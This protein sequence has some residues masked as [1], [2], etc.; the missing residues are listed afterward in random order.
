MSR[1]VI[2]L[3]SRGAAVS[4]CQTRLTVH[5]HSVTVDGIFGAGTDQA[6]RAFQRNHSLVAD[7]IVGSLTWDALDADPGEL[8]EPI[9]LWEVWKYAGMMDG[10]EYAD[11]A[12]T[13]RILL[14]SVSFLGWGYS[15]FG[16]GGEVRFPT[17]RLPGMERLPDWL[18]APEGYVAHGIDCSSLT[19]FLM[20]TVFCRTDWIPEDYEGFQVQDHTRPWS[21]MEST[22]RAGVGRRT[23]T[24]QAGRWYL[25]QAFRQIQPVL[26]GGHAR[27]CFCIDGDRLLVLESTT[28]RGEVGVTWSNATWTGL[29]Q[30]YPAGVQAAE[31]FEGPAYDLMAA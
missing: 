12:L 31:L 24:L 9:D 11:Q 8:P 25:T 6:V 17:R 1:P 20:L 29:L 27:I 18:F 19:A 26:S 3:G 15:G 14:A 7:G 10:D 21:P 28:A 13:A 2:S 4:D 22:E 30:K 5:G 23:S 16:N